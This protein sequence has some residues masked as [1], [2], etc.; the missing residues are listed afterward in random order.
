MSCNSK[1]DSYTYNKGDV[2]GTYY[3]FQI[4]SEKDFS[5]EIDCVFKAIDKA[6]NSYV[7][8]SEITNFNKNGITVKP[9]AT[10]LDMLEKAKKYHQISNGY[11][12][13][14]LLPL[15]K[16]WGSSLKNK[17][18]MDSTKVDSLMKF[19]SFKDLIKFNSAEV[20]ALK[21]GVEIDLSAMGEGY[22]LDAIASILNKSGVNNY[23]IE[24]GGEMTCKGVN[25]KGK[26]WQ[27]GIENPTVSIEKRETSLMKR[28]ELK[29]KGISTSGNYR[30]FYTDSLGNRYS[31]I[32]DAK[33][34][35]PVK[36]NL[37]SASI[38]SNS[39]TEADALAT[40]CMSMG[41]EKAKRFIENSPDIEGFLIYSEDKNLKSWQS[42]GFTK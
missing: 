6:V 4:D 30:K 9:S 41:T 13:P 28:V 17:E 40:A 26:V 23:M 20:K 21:Q 3:K 2:F 27:I 8:Y 42:S 29:N 18:Q 14:T 31:H 10:F 35:Y 37:L 22:A 1:K 24:I 19:V 33:M 36:H 25:A 32:I 12:E 7:D 5:K 11:F 15:I 34:G 39:S 38:I 16:N